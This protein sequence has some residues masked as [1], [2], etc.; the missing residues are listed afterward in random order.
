M[1]NPPRGNLQTSLRVGRGHAAETTTLAPLQRAYLPKHIH[2]TYQVSLYAH[3]PG[4]HRIEGQ[5]VRAGMGSFVVV[6][7]GDVHEGL[8][9]EVGEAPQTY[10]T[11]YLDRS[12]LAGEPTIRPDAHENARHFEAL[13]AFHAGRYDSALQEDEVRLAAGE[14]LRSLGGLLPAR[15]TGYADLRRA[16]ETIHDRAGEAIRLEEL[17]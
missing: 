10:L 4:L 8:D 13:R 3:A 12:A 6:N 17:A 11:L 1:S 7:P 5:V 9:L 16:R 14:A 15:W 2:E